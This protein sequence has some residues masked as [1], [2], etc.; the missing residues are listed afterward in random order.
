MLNGG[1]RKGRRKWVSPYCAGGETRADDGMAYT[2]T[3]NAESKKDG[4]TPGAADENVFAPVREDVALL[5]LSALAAFVDTAGF[6]ALY[7]L[8]IAHMTG[9]IVVAGLF[10]ANEHPKSV[11]IRLGV[12]PV[13]M[14]AVAGASLFARWV[15]RRNG[16]VLSLLLRCEAVALLAF[17]IAGTLWGG[18]VQGGENEELLFLLAIPG[19][20]AMGIQNL[21]TKYS[22]G[23][24]TPTTIMTGNLVQWTISGTLLLW[25]RLSPHRFDAT[26]EIQTARRQFARMN[27][28]LAGFLLGASAGAAG[29]IFFGF[30]S[31][32]VPVLIA[33]VLAVTS[34]M[35]H[36]K[37]NA[38]GK[39]VR[40]GGC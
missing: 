15:R 26:E 5:L 1:S 37:R 19:V 28:V 4:V 6:I 29:I 23:Q 9:N 40:D 20:A 11:L 25:H 35:A 27:F 32:L 7:G 31:L 2:D 17:L 8:F 39:L 10:L 12:V 14:V 36:Y 3:D 21:L 30:P 33:M 24:Q 18:R 34:E 38:Q 22:L 13:F 16:C